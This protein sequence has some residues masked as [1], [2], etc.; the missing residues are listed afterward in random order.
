VQYWYKFAIFATLSSHA[1]VISGGRKIPATDR[2]L[3][4]SKSNI[5]VREIK[6]IEVKSEIAAGTRGASLGVEALKIASLDLDSDY[7]T[8]YDSEEVENVNE[9]L[10]DGFD[11]P[12]AKFVDGVLIMEERVCLKVYET[13]FE[14]QF[15]IILAGDHS[16]AAGTICGI[17]KAN[18][19]SRV[20][21]IWID[22]H[23]DLHTPFTTPSGNMHGMPLAIAAAIDNLDCQI[24]D[25]K[26]ET[27]EYWEAL[28]NVGLPGPKIDLSDVV[29][30][31]MRDTEEPEQYL[32]AKHNMTV[33]T[34]DMI[35]AEGPVAIAH[36]AIKAL[37]HCDVLYV[38]FDVDSMDSKFSVG[39]GTPV[40]HGLTVD[41]ALAINTTLAAD[42]RLE[43]WEMVEVNPTL[44][45]ENRMAENAF[46]ILEATT[47]VIAE[48]LAK[49]E[50]QVQ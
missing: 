14:E 35:R 42:P 36:K 4:N 20:G 2:N 5:S 41:E 18:P 3:H 24:N 30:I 22:A 47:R 9:M 25:P 10:F 29:F 27:L 31:S 7:F 11:H 15:P 12:K 33:F 21:V 38:S 45:T 46:G 50:K 49:E 1:F 48:R 8:L 44:D 37:A 19:K 17:K 39:T 26:E 6:I 28:K 32:V 23:A 43:A 40:P 16:T 13:L 34:T